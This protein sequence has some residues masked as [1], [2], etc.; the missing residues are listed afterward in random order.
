MEQHKSI[1][2]RVVQ[3]MDL[4]TE[5]LPGQPLVEIVGAHRVLVEN[6]CGIIKYSCYEIL[7]KV[8]F[9]CFCISG[10]GLELLQM[11]KERLAIG[12]YIHGVSVVGKE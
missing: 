8:S 10:D 7:V 1:A 6:H 9:G 3:K 11:T 12:G 4:T 2:E 5:V